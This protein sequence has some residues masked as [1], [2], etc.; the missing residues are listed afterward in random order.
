MLHYAPVGGTWRGAWTSYGPLNLEL[1]CIHTLVLL[2]TE[3]CPVDCFSPSA[4]DQWPVG[5]G[6][7]WSG[8]YH[9]VNTGICGM[10]CDHCDRQN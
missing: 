7:A 4:S 5:V 8:N 1:C 9:G 2:E 3:L 6:L 10:G